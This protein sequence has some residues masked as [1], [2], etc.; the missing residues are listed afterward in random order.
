MYF[1]NMIAKSI[2]ENLPD[3]DKT[4]DAILERTAPR[5]SGIKWFKKP[6]AIALAAAL[7]IAASAIA[8]AGSVKTVQLGL[9]T[10]PAT[11]HQGAP[12]TLTVANSNQAAFQKGIVGLTMDIQ[13]DHTNLTYT[14]ET[15]SSPLTEQ[16]FSV[17]ANEATPGVITVLIYAD[18]DELPL[19]A[20]GNGEL[21]SLTFTVNADA[22]YGDYSFTASDYKL[23]DYTDDEQG[24][25]LV[26]VT[27]VPTPAQI[28]VEPPVN[29]SVDV[30]WGTMSF[31]YN[32]GSQG[33]WN[34][35]TH[36]YE[37][38]TPAGWT[39]AANANKITVT[40]NSNIA[41]AAAFQ[42]NKNPGYTDVTGTFKDG[43]NQTITDPVTLA[44]KTGET[45]PY[46][47]AYLTL[48]GSISSGSGV[49]IG[50]VTVTIDEPA[51]SQS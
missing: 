10:N 19:S 49:T 46:F 7:V 9:S 6:V 28:T 1:K 30:A 38:P 51:A 2:G 35:N 41:V 32:A 17:N 36:Q 11:C 14:N 23:A 31:T 33:T 50:T 43:S 18:N 24:F 26:D 5:A 44:A 48:S 8:I 12:V 39:Y 4:L 40:N 13:Y 42:Y 47:D 22:A 34:P 37:N 25:E 20:A 16:G 3:R 27:S 21:F 15:I 45:G 29:V